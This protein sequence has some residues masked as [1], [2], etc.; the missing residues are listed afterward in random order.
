MIK[1]KNTAAN[2]EKCSNTLEERISMPSLALLATSTPL[3]SA[4]LAGAVPEEPAGQ[5]DSIAPIA[6]TLAA[7]QESGPPMPA[8][9]PPPP[10]PSQPDPNGQPVGEIVVDGEVGPP[11]SD[12]LESVNEES[13][14]LVQS[15]DKAVIEPVADAYRDGLP[16]PVRDGLGNVVKNLG[17]PSNALNF[18]LQGKVGKAFETLGR[19][20]INTTVGVGGLFDV[21]GKKAGL[22][23][24]RNGFANTMGYYGVGPGPYLYLPVTGATTVRDFAGS[25]LDQLLLPLA[26]GRPFNRP[27]YAVTYFVVNGLDQ[28][29][30]FDE[31]LAKI[32]ASEDPYLMRRQTYLAKRRRDI[33]QLKGEPVPE[34]DNRWLEELEGKPAEAAPSAGE[35][36]AVTPPPGGAEALLITGGR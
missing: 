1:G 16:E 12:P 25:T 5:Q 29:L 17:E 18:L 22:P 7:A 9:P 19:L 2:R 31:E 23:Y 28:R 15:V 3:L 32:E 27:A 21:A 30:E 20:A 33:A 6:W 13:Y 36:P 24:R 10:S 4:A 35:E 8:A 26:V 34:E 11:K 14:R